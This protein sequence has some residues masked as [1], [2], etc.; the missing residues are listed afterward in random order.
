MSLA[1]KLLTIESL[2]HCDFCDQLLRSTRVLTE[3]GHRF[4]ELCVTDRVGEDRCCPKCKLPAIIKNVR[5]DP[6]HD[7]LVA[8]VRALKRKLVTDPLT[9]LSFEQQSID[10]QNF[11]LPDAESF[12]RHVQ[13]ASLATSASPSKTDEA[14]DMTKDAMIESPEKIQYVRESDDPPAPAQVSTAAPVA[15]EALDQDSQNS[16]NSIDDGALLLAMLDSEGVPEDIDTNTAKA[17]D[18]PT[19]PAHTTH[20]HTFHNDVDRSSQ[21]TSPHCSK[22]QVNPSDQT[23]NAVIRTAIWSST[24]NINEQSEQETDNYNKN[25]ND[26]E[27]NESRQSSMPAS[28]PAESY[29]DALSSYQPLSDTRPPT[30]IQ[31]NTNTESFQEEN[32]DDPVWDPFFEIP[33][34]TSSSFRHRTPAQDTRKRRRLM[35]SSHSESWLC[36]FCQFKNDARNDRCGVCR[37]NCE[38]PARANTMSQHEE[39]TLLPTMDVFSLPASVPTPGW[40]EDLTST[41]EPVHIL[42]TQIDE[43]LRNETEA[44]SIES[45]LAIH[46]HDSLRDIDVI[47]HVV[48]T[49]DEN[50]LA[51]RT[52]KYLHGIIA[53]KWIVD[54]EWLL[55]S[56]QTNQWQPELPYEA[57]GDTTLG[58]T[59]GPR[60]GR[61]RRA[62][63][64]PGLFEGVRFFFVGDFSPKYQKQELLHLCQAA[65]GAILNRRP[66]KQQNDT[67]VIVPSMEAP[68]DR[69]A[70]HHLQ[71]C[72]MRDVAWMLGHLSRCEP[73]TPP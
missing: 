11:K 25:D 32:Q 53:G 37:K 35:D 50:R 18:E 71:H 10:S 41:S 46:F 13:Q 58:P 66:T 45:S 56:L 43:A 14:D 54:N 15:R 51:K 9:P 31:D 70:M 67:Y 1:A 73:A 34:R 57:K 4:C 24:D 49:T 2:L 69:R 26:S 42:F 20:T 44:T 65:G 22:V 17:Q 6:R 28:Q 36:P 3:C 33:R 55:K 16:Q 23:E 21:H 30:T 61:V 59:G 60:K 27:N 64:D 47:T 39:A 8:C 52:G 12:R 5:R 38:A 72:Q 7:V 68:P 63:D 40:E 62:K 19:P 29:D 48:T